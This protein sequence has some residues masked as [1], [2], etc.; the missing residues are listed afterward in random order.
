MIVHFTINI[1]KRMIVERWTYD[2][3]SNTNTQIIRSITVH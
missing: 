3:Q 2:L 1:L